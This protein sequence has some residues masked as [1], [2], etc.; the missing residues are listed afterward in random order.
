[1][2]G[3]LPYGGQ[4]ITNLRA[5]RKRPADMV[6]VSLVGPLR[7]TNPVVI[8]CPDK[9]Y[10]WQFISGLEVLLVVETHLDANLVKHAADAILNVRPDYLGVWFC[11]C[12]DG[13]NLVIESDVLKSRSDR[14]MSLR[15][16]IAYAGIGSQ[17]SPHECRVEIARQTR[18]RAA[19][20]ADRFDS[21]LVAFA[22]AGFERL[23]GLAWMDAA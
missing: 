4:A 21:S 19:A 5:A 2:S 10:D 11:D 16:R 9:S 17:K 3:Y 18:A 15:Q 12:N 1:M 14:S 13:R 22:Q 20:N 8:A 23:F 7:E 6:L